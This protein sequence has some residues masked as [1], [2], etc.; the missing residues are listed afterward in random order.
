MSIYPCPLLPTLFGFP[1]GLTI[2]LVARR[3]LTSMRAGLM[4]RRWMGLTV[5]AEA[6][7]LDALVF[8][9]M[10]SCFWGLLFLCWCA[11]GHFWP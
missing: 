10:A 11:R 6:R 4:N 2:W 9:A 5:Y 3:D 7:A 1:L 8:S